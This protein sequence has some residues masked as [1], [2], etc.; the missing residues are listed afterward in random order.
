MPFSL[1]RDG[2]ADIF[3]AVDYE[4]E[5][6]DPEIT[7]ESEPGSA[8]DSE[9]ESEPDSEPEF[10]PDF[11][12]T[13]PVP[14]ILG[15]VNNY[16]LLVYATACFLMYFSLLGI[17]IFSERIVLSLSL[18]GI[19]AFILPLFV[20]AKRFSLS[21][22]KAYHIEV[23]DLRTTL[24]VL[25]ISGSSIIPVEIFSSIFERAW[26]PDADYISFILSIKPKGILSFIAI[27]F[28]LVIIAPLGEELLFR[29]FIQRI[30]QRNMG[31]P[32]AVILASVVFAIVHFELA[33]IPSIAVL[34]LIFGYIFYRT[35]NLLYPVMAHGLYNFVS[36]LR[37]HMTS[38]TDLEEGGYETVSMTWGIV[39]SILLL[40]GIML[41]ERLNATSRETDDD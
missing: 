6:N 40:L 9:P 22:T 39:S 1:P 37:L 23:P 26:P 21:F 5:Q 14:D 36:L 20:L 13:E 28:G 15:R 4:S 16:L 18:P 24:C 27:A 32:V 10:E 33:I 12:P 31:G 3:F 25:F 35:G 7:P 30:F 34:G 17:L 11:E 29:G 38:V 8:P 19:V 41:L 2:I